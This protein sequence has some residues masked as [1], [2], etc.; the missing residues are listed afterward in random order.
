VN[1]LEEEKE[2]SPTA[3]D[4]YCT[5]RGKQP[6]SNDKVSKTI[7]SAK[8]SEIPR[9]TWRWAWKQPSVKKRVTT[10]KKRDHAPEIQETKYGTEAV[11]SSKRKK[12]SRTFCKARKEVERLEKPLDSKEKEEENA[13]R[14]ENVDMSNEKDGKRIHSA[15]NPKVPDSKRKSNRVKKGSE[16]NQTVPNG[17]LKG[18]ARWEAKGKQSGDYGSLGKRQSESEVKAKAQRRT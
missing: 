12:G 6:R 11:I 17:K 13:I 9:T 1:K 10:Y 3:V 2:R 8:G 14:S 15:E 7:L 4:K 16:K 5:L 18:G